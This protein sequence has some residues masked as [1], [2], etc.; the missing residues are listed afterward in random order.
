MKVLSIQS[1]G[2]P[3]PRRQLRGRVPPP[4]HRGRGRRRAHRELL[5]PHRLRLVARARH[6]RRRRRRRPRRRRGA[7]GVPRDRRRAVRLPGRH[8]HRRRHRRRGAPREGREPRRGLRV[9]P[10]HGQRAGPAAS[11]PRRSPICCA[12]GSC[13]SPTSSPR[14]S[15]SSGSSPGPSPTTMESTLASADAARA[16]G[17]STVLITSVERPDRED[18]T[19]EMAAV[20]DAGAW[21][22]QTPL[23]PFTANGSGDVTAALFSAH[24]RAH[25]RPGARPGAHGLAASSTS[26]RPP[27][28][29]VSGNCA[30]SR[31]RRCSRTPGCSSAPGG[32]ADPSPRGGAHP[33]P[34]GGADPSLRGGDAR[35]GA[36]LAGGAGAQRVDRRVAVGQDLALHL[37]LAHG[38]RLQEDG[39]DRTGPVVGGAG[40]LRGLPRPGRRRPGRPWCAPDRA[41]PCR[42][43]S[44]GCRRGCAAAQRSP[45]PDR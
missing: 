24:H 34:R 4:A 45:R 44:S 32:S 1:A 37:R 22:V 8:R 13:P 41:G 11:S 20:A 40:G 43:S 16:T 23:V 12:T 18:G 27:T 30:S 26:S 7:R 29:R 33:S 3:R 28:A 15:S 36:G 42:P 6:V 21:V 5:Q 39:G 10:G 35:L 19:L 38:L 9:R 31:S 2:G 17:P 25:R 14:T